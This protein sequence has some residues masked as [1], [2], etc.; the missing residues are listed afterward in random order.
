LELRR[1]L[2]LAGFEFRS[3]TDTEVLLHGYQE[4]GIDA[5]VARLRGMFAFGLWDNRLRK[6]YLV[7]D[8]LGV[9]PLV[10]ATHGK[11]I[12]FASTV[13]ALRL[14]G[15]AGDLDAKG[16]AD[17]LEWGF[18]PDD[19]SIYQDVRKV[20]A[21]TIVEWS[22]GATSQRRYWALPTVS[23]SSNSSF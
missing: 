6:L 23:D 15:Y 13:R 9:K 22:D 20:P 11:V 12:A 17:F 16:L 18:I 1:E 4:W 14:A 2:I 3:N 19:H 8:R 21:A 10:F 7:R 5:L